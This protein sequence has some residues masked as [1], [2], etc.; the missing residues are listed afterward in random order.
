MR[1]VGHSHI[2]IH[3]PQLDLTR[4]A[5]RFELRPVLRRAGVDEGVV[6]RGQALERWPALG[7]QT[8]PVVHRAM[9]VRTLAVARRL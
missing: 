6:G 7:L 8:T 3:P 2:F 4:A 5:A 1:I 9:V